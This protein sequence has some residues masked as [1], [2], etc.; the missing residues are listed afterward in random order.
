MNEGQAIIK[1]A[2]NGYIVSVEESRE[3][4]DK[5]SKAFRKLL[6][7]TGAVESWQEDKLHQIE[8]LF[9]DSLGL[10]ASFTKTYIFKTFQEAVSFLYTYFEE[11]NP[12]LKI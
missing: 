6:E 9:K 2:E 7:V 1:K 10:Q 8:K 11:L 5:Y 12:P 4:R 3:L